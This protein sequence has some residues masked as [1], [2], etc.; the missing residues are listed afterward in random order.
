MDES[1]LEAAGCG[2]YVLAA[3]VF[4]PSAEQHARTEMLR[5]RGTRAISKL[6][7][8]EMDIRQRHAAARTVGMLDSMSV[9]TVGTPVPAKRQE[10]ARAKCLE[11]MVTELHGWGVEL[12]LIEAR[13]AQLDDRDLRTVIGARYNLPKGA[14]FR[15]EHRTGT[16]EPLFWAADIVAGAVRAERMGEPDFKA[17]LADHLCEL[18]VDT[19]CGHA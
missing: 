1:F 10:R 9:V 18:A 14:R 13:T 8:N 19:G 6:H 16:A 15:T 5:L 2:F 11:R 7:W 17:A 12:L 4:D 3:A